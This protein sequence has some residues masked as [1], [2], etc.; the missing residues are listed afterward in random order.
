MYR[1]GEFSKI[2]NLSIR[3][4]RYYNDIGLLIPEKVDIF[5]NYRYY[6]D[7]NLRQ[8]K[9][10]EKLKSVGFSLDEIKKYWG[11]F[12][13]DIFLKKKEELLKEMEI[14]ANAIRKI[15]KIRNEFNN[16]SDMYCDKAKKL[17]MEGNDLYDEY[18]FNYR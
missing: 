15:D 13:D 6:G 1:I 5:T 17:V 3:T 10:I 11:N 9:I 12:S 7:I 2:T 18:K 8:V 4:L 16:N 14:K